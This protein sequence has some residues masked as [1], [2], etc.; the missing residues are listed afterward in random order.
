[1][2]ADLITATPK[3][4]RNR[5]TILE[6]NI[7][8]DKEL[9]PVGLTDPLQI[10]S[11]SPEC[12]WTKVN[13]GTTLATDVSYSDPSRKGS[14]RHMFLTVPNFLCCQKAVLAG[15]LVAGEKTLR[16]GCASS[17]LDHVYPRFDL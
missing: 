2:A 12:P 1:M 5:K 8:L 11:H 15:D 16:G 14:K 9:V 10:C 7:S 6:N 13:R 3:S 17:R 4:F